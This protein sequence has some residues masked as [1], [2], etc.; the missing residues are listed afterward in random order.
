[1]SAGGLHRV[2][3]GPYASQAKAQ[4]ARD[5]A[6]RRGYAGAQIVHVD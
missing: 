1:V 4:S 3:L 6:V 5:G 2:R